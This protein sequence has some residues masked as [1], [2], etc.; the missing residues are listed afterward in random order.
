MTDFENSGP[1]LLPDAPSYGLRR[2][3]LAAHERSRWRQGALHA[4]PQ[5]LQRPTGWDGCAPFLSEGLR[6]I[7]WNTRILC[8]NCAFQTEEQRVLTQLYQKK[9]LD[10]NNIICLQEVHGKDEYLQ[11]IQVLAPRFSFLVLLFL[12]MKMLG[13]WAICIHMD[14]FS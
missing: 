8:W 10:H 6:C 5:I 1:S 2:V 13:G 3:V 14:L 9:L 12:I 4:Q 11:A 7:T